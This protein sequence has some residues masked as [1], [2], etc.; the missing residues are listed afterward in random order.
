LQ[1]LVL[2]LS[3]DEWIEGAEGFIHQQHIGLAASAL[4]N[5]TRCCI[6]PDSSAGYRSPQPDKLNELECLLCDLF[7]LRSRNAAYFQPEGDVLPDASMRKKRDVLEDHADPLWRGGRA[8]H[9]PT[10]C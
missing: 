9:D 10:W 5:P 3:S 1:K 4:A 6:P 8:I 7:S 2:Q